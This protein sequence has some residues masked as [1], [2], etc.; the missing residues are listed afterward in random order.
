MMNASTAFQILMTKILKIFNFKIALVYI[1][2]SLI[3]SK[4]FDQH[5]HHLNL[6]FSNLRAA[7]LTLLHVNCKFAIK[8]GKYLGHIVSKDGSK[9]NPENTD[10]IGNCQRA[11]NIKQVRIALG[12]MGHYTKFV[13]D[14]AKLHYL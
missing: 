3:F 2:D 4:D 14:Y 10:K 6:V 8:Q 13:K 11:I 12:M 7:N 1:D 9:T 5:L